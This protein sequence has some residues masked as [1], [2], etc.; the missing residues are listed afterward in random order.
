[1]TEDWTYEAAAAWYQRH[2]ANESLKALLAQ[3]HSLLNERMLKR[4]VPG[5]LLLSAANERAIEKKANP[6]KVKRE[7]TTEVQALQ[8]EWRRLYKEA[9]YWHQRLT[10]LH[11][12]E[13]REKALFILSLFEQVHQIWDDLAHF[14]ATGSLPQ[15]VVH[16][17]I[18]Y[19]H[20]DKTELYKELC[21]VRSRISKAK[22]GE[23]RAELTAVKL[24]IEELLKNAV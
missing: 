19:A 3:G 6:V 18:D 17:Q 7:E 4:E 15:K 13:R 16:V 21:R 8:A 24:R 5:T 12:D 11:T 1:M 14:E 2:G 20:W 23:K 22:T 9:S 10:E